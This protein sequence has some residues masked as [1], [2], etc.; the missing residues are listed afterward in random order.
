MAQVAMEPTALEEDRVALETLC[1]M[2]TT[3]QERRVKDL[4]VALEPLALAMPL[5][6]VEVPVA[7]EAMPQELLLEL[8][9]S[10]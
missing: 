5:V 1:R 3:L 7:Q 10:A 4:P 2:P 9:E 6:V 8:V